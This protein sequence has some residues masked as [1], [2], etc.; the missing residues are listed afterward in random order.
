MRLRGRGGGGNY[1]SNHSPAQGRR[2]QSDSP[3]PGRRHSQRL[4]AER[5]VPPGQVSRLVGNR[6]LLRPKGGGGS[7]GGP[8]N[9][10]RNYSPEGPCFGRQGSRSPT[11]GPRAVSRS[12]TRGPFSRNAAR[13][14][15]RHHEDR[16]IS[17]SPVPIFRHSDRRRANLSPRDLS[18]FAKASERKRERERRENRP[19]KR[20]HSHAASEKSSPSTHSHPNI[21]APA[22]RRYT[23]NESPAAPKIRHG[24]DEGSPAA[25]KPRHGRDDNSPAAPKNRHG[26]DD[27]SPAAPK[28]RHGRGDGSPAPPA[29]RRHIRDHGSP[30]PHATRRYV[31]GEGSPLPATTRRYVRDEESPL[32]GAN[33]RRRAREENRSPPPHTHHHH[34]HHHHHRRHTRE[35]ES[36]VPPT[37]HARGDNYR[38]RHHESPVQARSR[39]RSARHRA[40]FTDARRR[41]PSEARHV[42]LETR[43][44]SPDILPKTIEPPA[45]MS[46]KARNFFKRKIRPTGPSLSEHIV[47]KCLRMVGPLGGNC[48][49]G[50]VASE[51]GVSASTLTRSF[52]VQG[53]LLVLTKS[54]LARAALLPT[55]HRPRS[56]AGR[57]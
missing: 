12:P 50:R 51:L 3:A 41:E 27:N 5:G 9:A 24:R 45:S 37:R 35:D 53:P 17:V 26:R 18:E 40:A 36:P 1:D 25:R 30:A 55:E 49:I 52:H 56:R 11:R 48:F 47:N 44:E 54:Q 15:G 46:E 23:R 42:I 20:R 6:G 32:P 7:K 31:H 16:E 33:R 4:N 34:H 38:S 28:H 2:Y 10:L 57:G 21:P 14:D 8:R 13:T 22:N 29:N 39:S 43:S 19:A